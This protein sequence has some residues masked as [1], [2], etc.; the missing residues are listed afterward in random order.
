MRATSC[1]FKSHLRHKEK[2]TSRKKFQLKRRLK[3][4]KASENLQKLELMILKKQLEKI[5]QKLPASILAG[6]LI[7]LEKEKQ[8]YLRQNKKRRG[9]REKMG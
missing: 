5:L 7:F 8:S 1:G 2:L 3:H 6:F 9:P 4:P